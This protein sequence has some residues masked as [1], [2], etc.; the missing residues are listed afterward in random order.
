MNQLKAFGKLLLL[1][2]IPVLFLAIEFKFISLNLLY[3]PLIIVVSILL[4]AHWIKQLSLNPILK[5]VVLV[6]PTAIFVYSLIVTQIKGLWVLLIL[7]VITSLIGLM[8]LKKRSLIITYGVLILLTSLFSYYSLPKIVTDNLFETTHEAVPSIELENLLEEGAYFNRAS[9]EGKVTILD[10]FGTWCAPCI[11]EMRELQ[12]IQ[13]DLK[14]YEDQLQ[15]ITIC[16]EQG[17]DTPD[18]ARKYLSKREVPFDLAFD[19]DSKA[20]KAFGLRGV[21]GLVVIDKQGNTR[22]KH[23]GFNESE[24]FKEALVPILLELLKQ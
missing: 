8:S 20:L 5:T 4:S 23:V 15:I 18:K 19:Y 9:L 12:E 11:L 2:L 10:F 17:G 22:I 21:P 24:H 1:G 13:E 16:I 7:I 6:S 14:E 3:T